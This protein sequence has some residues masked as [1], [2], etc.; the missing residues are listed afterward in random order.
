MDLPNALLLHISLRSGRKHSGKINYIKFHAIRWLEEEAKDELK[1]SSVLSVLRKNK[2]IV[3]HKPNP[4]S[5]LHI[6]AIQQRLELFC[7]SGEET[8]PSISASS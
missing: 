8:S 7:T 1:I 6:L 5:L 4:A 3:L 2:K